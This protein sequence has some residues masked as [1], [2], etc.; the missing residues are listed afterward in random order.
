[1]KW[2][3]FDFL[4]VWIG[5]FYMAKVHKSVGFG[6]A[7]DELEV[8]MILA[9]SRFGIMGLAMWQSTAHGNNWKHCPEDESGETHYK[10]IT[11][12]YYFLSDNQFVASHRSHK[13]H[14]ERIVDFAFG[15]VLLWDPKGSVVATDAFIPRRRVCHPA[16]NTRRSRQAASLVRCS[17]C[18]IRE[19]C[20]K[21]NICE[22]RTYWT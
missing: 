9:H 6:S 4:S 20:V 18:E 7:N 14:K 17:L 10:P 8:A 21:S 13:S 11:Y 12:C 16:E 19:I 2:A 5:L 15:L 1:M 3:F 22:R